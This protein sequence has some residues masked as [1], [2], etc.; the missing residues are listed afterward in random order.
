MKPEI[1]TQQDM[2]D[3]LKANRPKLFELL[4]TKP[5]FEILTHELL[6]VERELTESKKLN[7]RRDDIMADDYGQCVPTG[8][9]LLQ[10]QMFGE[11]KS[12]EGNTYAFG[13]VGY[14]ALDRPVPYVQNKGTRRLFAFD[15]TKLIKRAMEAGLDRE[16]SKIL[17]PR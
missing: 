5:L 17:I 3:W 12:S 4:G 9:Q 8:L 11:A 16:D 2:V 10:V 15:W 1:N 14:P 13:V 6:D 7:A